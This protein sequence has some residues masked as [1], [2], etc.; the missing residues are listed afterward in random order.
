[1][2]AFKPNTLVMLTTLSVTSL[3]QSAELPRAP[4]LGDTPDPATRTISSIVYKNL[5]TKTQEV[6]EDAA[7]EVNISRYID[8]ELWNATKIRTNAMSLT[9]PRTG[10]FVNNDQASFSVYAPMHSVNGAL[11]FA[12][13]VSQSRMNDSLVM[14]VQALSF[15]AKRQINTE[16]SYS[17]KLDKNSRFD[18]AISYSFSPSSSLEK[19]GVVVS[20]R[21]N[22]KF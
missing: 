21:Y 8:K 22:V 12:G 16:F 3:A 17:V 15:A 9:I 20:V 6:G 13:Y 10:I 14:L 7:G 2:N 5:V 11:S 18:S 4:E 19:S 1:M